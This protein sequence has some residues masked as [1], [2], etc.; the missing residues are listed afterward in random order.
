MVYLVKLSI[1]MNMADLIA[2]I[3]KASSHKNM[4]KD[5][6]TVNETFNVLTPL[7]PRLAESTLAGVTALNTTTQT[8]G[9]QSCSCRK[10][11]E[12]VREE[13]EC[14]VWDG[15]VRCRLGLETMDESRRNGEG[16]PP[17]EEIARLGFV[18]Y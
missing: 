1:E 8:S 13:V 11:P 9:H 16:R 3:A 7:P 10:D 18:S 2:K 5:A 14:A 17:E 15:C 6:R 12:D 4:P